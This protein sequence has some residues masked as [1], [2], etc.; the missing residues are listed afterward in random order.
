MTPSSFRRCRMSISC[1][2][3]SAEAL[4]KGQVV[5]PAWHR[6]VT[7]PPA[8]SGWKGGAPSAQGLHIAAYSPRNLLQHSAIAGGQIQCLR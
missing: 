2:P 1:V 4:H 3:Y 7:C 8:G 5:R 6:S